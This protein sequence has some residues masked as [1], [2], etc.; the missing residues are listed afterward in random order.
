MHSFLVG[1][2]SFIVQGMINGAVNDARALD[3]RYI[4]ILFFFFL[5]CSFKF[6]SN[7]YVVYLMQNDIFGNNFSF[8]L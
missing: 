2:C 5:G 8:G 6:F 1:V 3:I 4:I 7:L